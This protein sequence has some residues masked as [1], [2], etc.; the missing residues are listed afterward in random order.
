MIEVDNTLAISLPDD[1]IT[2]GA[3]RDSLVLL[4]LV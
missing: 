1:F 4:P 2:A 3:E